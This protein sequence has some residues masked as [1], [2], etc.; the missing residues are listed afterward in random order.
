MQSSKEWDS[1]SLQSINN[2]QAT[3]NLSVKKSTSRHI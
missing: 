1:V 3:E 2:L